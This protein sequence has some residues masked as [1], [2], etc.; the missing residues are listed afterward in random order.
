[1]FLK[2]GS[3]TPRSEVAAQDAFADGK[4][5]RGREEIH[6]KLNRRDKGLGAFDALYA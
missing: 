2:D 5:G 3:S 6:E 1:L 4:I